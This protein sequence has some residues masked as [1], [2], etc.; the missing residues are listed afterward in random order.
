M[1]KTKLY[2]FL[3]ILTIIFL[4]SFA[5]LCN[6]CGTATEEEKID[7]GDEGEA[8][9]NEE[10]EAAA[11]AEEEEVTEEEAAP[12]EEEEEEITDEEKE[13]PTIKLEIYEGPAPADGICYYRV[14]AIVTGNPT[15]SI[16][17]SK[18][19]SNGVWG[20]YKAQVNLN[21]PSDTYNLTATATNSE[22][23]ATDSINLNWGCLALNNPPEIVDIV[24][25]AHPKLFIG[26]PYSVTCFAS[27]P[28][29]DNLT[30]EWSVVGQGII[31][32]PHANPM[33]WTPDMDMDH[34]ITVTVSD[35]KGGVT[36]KTITV[37]VNLPEV[38][39][40][41]YIV[42]ES[43]EIEKNF[44]AYPGNLP[45]IGDS[46]RNNSVRGFIS[47]DISGY[48]EIIVT[49]ARLDIEN[50]L[51][52]GSPTPLIEKIWVGVVDWGV[53][54][55]ELSDYDL[56]ERLIWEYH[57]P[58]VYCA[59]EELKN[60]LQTVLDDGKPRFQVRIRHKGFQSNNNGIWDGWRYQTI[61]LVIQYVY[62]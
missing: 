51:T 26:L 13:A 8:V 53:G 5:A 33:K 20:K 60:E 57:G 24:I 11:P 30:Y 16:E 36:S 49:G 3:V 18:D 46:E 50:Y 31:D 14:K 23:A 25:P 37:G 19:D 55:I 2:F 56:Q 34:D 35:G 17:F 1:R 54:P 38:V 12:A 32:D 48:S 21:D 47:F 29:G 15:P 58:L 39:I 7:V 59:S 40:L 41:D 43:G 52:N 42:S 44:A 28:D 45:Y 22:G 10:E 27:D 62:Y 61:K 9:A 6:Q 4:F